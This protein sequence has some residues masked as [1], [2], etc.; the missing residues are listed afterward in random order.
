MRDSPDGN[1]TAA[2]GLAITGLYGVLVTT[3]SCAPSPLPPLGSSDG[4]ALNSI[5]EAQPWDLE[6]APCLLV[7]A[8]CG[9]LGCT[10]YVV[11]CDG[12]NDQELPGT[13]TPAYIPALP[14][15]GINDLALVSATVWGLLFFD[16]AY[17]VT[18]SLSILCTLI[19]LSQTGD[20]LP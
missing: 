1:A 11:K 18:I 2:V 13:T 10:I 20:V 17:S 12:E 15:C 9:V 5:L 16:A 19:C 4:Q 7:H 14:L 3:A 6:C 8:R